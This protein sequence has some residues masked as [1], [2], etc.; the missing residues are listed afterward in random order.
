M[1]VITA[2]L[3]FWCVYASADP[4]IKN[5]GV[6]DRAYGLGNNFT[7]VSNDF[8]ALFWNPAGM[9]FVPVRE[10]HFAMDWNREEM[11]GSLGNA[12]TDAEKR[13]FRVSSSGLLRSLP[14][15]RGGFAFAL[16][17]MSPWRLDDLN[18]SRGANVYRGI[19]PIEG[20]W[21]TI[22]PGDTV[23]RYPNDKNATGS[24]NLWSAGMGW[25]IAPGLGFGFSL[26]LLTGSET[27]SRSITSYLH[28]R[29]FENVA[30]TMDRAY[31][32]YDLRAGLL[33]KPV[34]QFSLGC[35][36]EVPRYAKVAE[37][38]NELS[39]FG[40]WD[41]TSFGVL[42]SSLSGGLGCA[43]HLPFA[44]ISADAVGR[45]PLPD[46]PATT[47]G[48]YC[49]GGGGAGIEVPIP[50]LAS[51]VRGGYA[52]SQ[53]DLSPMHIVWDEEGVENEGN[54]SALRDRHLFTA[55][56][57]LLIAGGILFEAAYGYQA[58]K[59]LYRDPDWENGI[60]ESHRCHR[61]MASV[62]IRY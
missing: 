23:I 39:S 60:T 37:T 51:L 31:I 52:Y 18:Y 7:A 14:T 28:Q 11:T 4:T 19:D 32:G 45:A 22:M 20:E 56:Y 44:T 36:I 5:A 21:D 15:T 54:I 46:A 1:R 30:I 58:W 33:Y 12:A 29:L 10:A 17:F 48:S 3:L 40:T 24:L 59:F 16:G 61:A 42:K 41:T 8:S 35:R 34:K 62:S 49:K 6:G 57:S 38:R 9:A 50:W 13:H 47:D 27:K 2:T 53:T 55:G 25:Q 26:G 43:L